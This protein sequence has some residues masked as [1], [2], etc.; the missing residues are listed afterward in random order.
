M[1]RLLSRALVFLA[2]PSPPP[3]LLFALNLPHRLAAAADTLSI[4]FF[5]GMVSTDVL[6]LLHH[7]F[8]NGPKNLL[9][10]HPSTGAL[11]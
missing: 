8:W 3:L 2:L 9:H 7:E 1:L 4:C 10:P 6:L 11:E 5:S